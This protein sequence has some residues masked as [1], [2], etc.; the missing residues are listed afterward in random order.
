MKFR[1]QLSLDVT[2]QSSSSKND[3]DNGNTFAFGQTTYR[4]DHFSIGQDYLR[5]EGRTV[6]RGQLSPDQLHLQ[7]I[8]G[9][10]N[11]S[12]VRRASWRRHGDTT[13]PVA[14]KQL[15]LT[16]TSQT[17]Q[18]MLLQELRTLCLLESECLVALH[19]AFLEQDVIFMVLEMMDQG[20]LQDYFGRHGNGVRL[21]N[22][23]IA[24][25]SLQ[26]LTGL[27]HLHAQH[28]IHR[29]LKP[30]NILLHSTGHV[31]LCDFGM[32]TLTEHSLQTTVVGTTK[33]M[34]PERLRG[35]PYG[36][37]SDLWSFGLVVWQCVTGCEPWADVHSL[38]D[39]VVT[40]EET[41]VQSE[42]LPMAGVL[43]P[44]LSELLM[45]C[46]QK[47]PGKLSS[48]VRNSSSMVYFSLTHTLVENMA[49]ANSCTQRNAFQQHCF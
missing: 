9:K 45:A 47:I 41:D 42:L 36:R 14:V 22:D 26:V 10:G 32:T 20:S 43:H 12:T 5:L 11:F 29:D 21:N 8:V 38:V 2:S 6:S 37:A 18:A 23:F 25:V 27:S 19:G 44:G 13:I 16:Q 46:L 7:H 34:P 15:C 28:M 49:H 33:Y 24:A 30:A 3:D 1:P 40:V 4:K 17:R 48:T 35:L 31:K 39:L